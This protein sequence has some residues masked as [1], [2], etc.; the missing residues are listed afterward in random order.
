MMRYITPETLDL[1]T[2]EW[3]H[4]IKPF[5]KHVWKINPDKA[6]LLV[7]DCQNYFVSDPLPEGAPILKNI[8]KLIA[9]F[10]KAQRPIIFTRHMHKADGSDLGIIGKWWDENIIEDTYES[11]IHAS[12][13]VKTNDIVIRKNVYSS[14]INTNLESI[15]KTLRVE[16]LVITG[17]MTNL[18]CETTARDAFC[19]NYRV[20]FLADATGTIDE[21]M[22]IATLINISFGFA[23]V[24][25]SA[26]ILTAMGS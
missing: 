13:E 8:K 14:F 10:R 1:K 26:D 7:I 24:V 16:D 5:N 4:K 18:C 2:N 15:L 22:H 25:R 17:V 20:F 9:S 21:A 3:L 19:L 11:E 23:P 12:L 6:A